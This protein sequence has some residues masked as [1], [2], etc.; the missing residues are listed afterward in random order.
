MPSSG[1]FPAKILRLIGAIA[2]EHSEADFLLTFHLSHIYCRE[3]SLGWHIFGEL[4]FGKKVELLRKA[5]RHI[6]PEKDE[7]GF[8]GRSEYE[9]A[10]DLLSQLKELS[11]RRNSLLH[12]IAHIESDGDIAVQRHPNKKHGGV[13][14]DERSLNQV[15]DDLRMLSAK[16]ALQ[17]TRI[18]KDV[19]NRQEAKASELKGSTIQITTRS[20][21]GR[22]GNRTFQKLRSTRKVVPPGIN[23]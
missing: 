4:F 8:L 15:L 9:S 23:R 21:T 6:M 12:G 20:I 3:M 11:E 19:R 22:I 18:G 10:L 7:E 2:V 16:L 17:A 14:L 13:N 1:E 5:I